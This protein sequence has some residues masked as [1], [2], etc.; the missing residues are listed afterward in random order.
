M[1]EAIGVVYCTVHD[2]YILPEDSADSEACLSPD[3]VVLWASGSELTKRS[4]KA[5]D[6]R[7]NANVMPVKLLRSGSSE[8][9]VEVL[10]LSHST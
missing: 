4:E 10:P 7:Y 5:V 6:L 2:I 9:L 3:S 8:R 1:P